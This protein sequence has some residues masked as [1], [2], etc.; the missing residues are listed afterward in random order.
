[1]NALRLLTLAAIWGASFLFMRMAAP[2]FGV[3]PLI[4]L[5]VGLAALLLSPILR[6]QAARSE[7]RQ[8]LLPLLIVGV[9]NSALPFCLLT[10]A[11]LYVTAGVDSILNAS[12]P[13]WTALLAYV[14]WQLTLSRTQILGLLLGFVGVLI[15]AW[16]TIGHG[17]NG[18]ALAVL[19]ALLATL[20]Y[21][22]AGNYSRQHLAAVSPMVSAFGSQFF[23]ALTLLPSACLYWPAH[24]IR[25]SSWFALLMLAA[26]CSAIAYILYF[27]LIR[28][29]GAQFAAS[30]TF[31][32]PI[33][34]VLWGA[35]FLQEAITIQAVLGCMIILLGTA[36][37]SGRIKSG[38]LA[39]ASS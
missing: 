3:I 12:T 9:S 16:D 8:H 30:V 25:N 1:M 2:D 36:L 13:L 27:G 4:A 20:S 29:R 6:K 32:I 21:G 7:F 26:L 39:K 33:F 18:T 11:A 35:I 14:W 5:R 24:A 10:Y 37:A 34:G 15:L 28:Q 31:L 17:S 22:F 38:R 19:A 23:A